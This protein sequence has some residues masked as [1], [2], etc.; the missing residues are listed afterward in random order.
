MAQRASDMKIVTCKVIYDVGKLKVMEFCL[1]L[2]EEVIYQSQ[3]NFAVLLL[4]TS[5]YIST[6]IY[7]NTL[8]PYIWVKRTQ[9]NIMQR[10]VTI[11]QLR[12]L[13]TP[14]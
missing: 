4:F 12:S 6:L 8:E 10:S 14:T 5:F 9:M 7:Y 2:D 3:R 13:N 1:E 11:F